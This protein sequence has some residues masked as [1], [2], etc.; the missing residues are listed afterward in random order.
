M[1]RLAKSS[2]KATKDLTQIKQIKNEEGCI[3]SEETDIKN[4][5]KNN[6][7]KLLNE[8]NERAFSK[9]ESQ[10]RKKQQV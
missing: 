3:L 9:W 8:E 4:K 2:N 6:F 10:M 7:E 5:W 1:Y